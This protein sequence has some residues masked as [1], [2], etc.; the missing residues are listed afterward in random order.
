MGF[1]ISPN[2]TLLILLPELSVYEF[3]FGLDIL[4]INHKKPPRITNKTKQ[5]L[6]GIL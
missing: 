6:S 3:V 2:P 4:V 5:E 1:V